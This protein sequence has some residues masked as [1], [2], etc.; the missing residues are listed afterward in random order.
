MHE[1]DSLEVAIEAGLWFSY[2]RAKRFDVT[3]RTTFDAVLLG[4]RRST[5]RFARWPGHKAWQ[6][7]GVGDLVRFHARQDRAGRSLVVQVSSVQPIDLA[8]CDSDAL[9]A[10]SLCEGWSPDKGRE[11]GRELGHALWFGH[12]LVSPLVQTVRPVQMS[13]L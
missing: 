1:S 5:T 3:A 4:E 7:I 12:A 11:M 9:E 13:L 2:G 6:A 8:T 10:W